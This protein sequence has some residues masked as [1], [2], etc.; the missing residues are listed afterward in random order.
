[1]AIGEDGEIGIWSKEQ[2]GKPI[3]GQPLL[4]SLA[5]KGQWKTPTKSKPLQSAI[6]AKGRAMVFY[7]RSAT[8]GAVI[9]LQHFDPGSHQSTPTSPIDL[10][11][12]DLRTSDD[13]SMILAVSDI[14]DGISGKGRRTQRAIVMAVSR[15][16]QAWTWRISSRYATT[17]SS[18]IDPDND[19]P[20]IQLLHKYRLP[21][22]G[23][24]QPAWVLP[25][26][27]MG[28]HQSVIDWNTDTPLQD[29]VLTIS[30]DGVLEYWQPRLGQHLADT[31]G[32]NGMMA[33]TSRENEAGRPWARSGSVETGR[34][35]IVRARCSSRK[36]TVL[37]ESRLDFGHRAR[38]IHSVRHAGRKTRNYNMGLERQRVLDRS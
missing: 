9:S 29:M 17:S 32:I 3:P 2:V 37:G 12:F 15:A 31:E 36:K 26:D 4:K 24:D 25:V 8:N 6:F 33:A 22:Q 19:R 14:D 11:G 16:G 7:T 35:S 13:I 38:L 34:T 10:P 27:P 21:V 28:W 5:G 18:E 30:K 20:D 23:G 1:M